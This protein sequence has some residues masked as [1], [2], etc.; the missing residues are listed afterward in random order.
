MIQTTAISDPSVLDRQWQPVGFNDEWGG[1]LIGRNT[2]GCLSPLEAAQAIDAAL[3]AYVEAPLITSAIFLIPRVMQRDWQRV[4]KYCVALGVFAPSVVPTK[5]SHDIPFVLCYL[6][7]HVPTMP[8][9]R[10]SMDCSAIP[11]Y[12][13]RHLRFA[14]TLRGMQGDDVSL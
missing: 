4:S 7:P 1:E 6:K 5:V 11:G 2:L 14:D 8:S 9:D 3:M 13:R 12:L 10:E